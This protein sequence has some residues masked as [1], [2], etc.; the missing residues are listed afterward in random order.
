MNNLDALIQL[1]LSIWMPK[2]SVRVYLNR[3]GNQLSKDSS[4]SLW[5]S[6]QINFGFNQTVGVIW[7]T[8]AKRGLSGSSA[9]V[10]FYFF[11]NW[12]DLNWLVNCIVLL[13]SLRQFLHPQFA[14][15]NL[16]SNAA[17]DTA[18][19]EI[20]NGMGVRL[21]WKGLPFKSFRL[22]YGWSGLFH[23][24]S[25]CPLKHGRAW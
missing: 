23:S 22:A 24:I 25:D 1:R 15:R 16:F 6:S 13:R 12:D 5:N 11:L 4:F 8:K 9:E 18:Q 17:F 19:M 7:C 14:K 10:R 2:I 3:T 21:S 20:E